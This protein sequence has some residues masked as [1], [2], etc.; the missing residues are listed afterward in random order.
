M[1]QLVIIGAR[2]YGR[3]I[4]DFATDCR[5]YNSDYTI[6]GFL[7]D[8]K[9]ALDDHPGYPPI[10]DSVENY[11]PREDDVF[12]CA[13]GEVKYKKK[14]CEMILAKGGIFTTLISNRAYVSDRNTK[15]GVGC[16]IC[17]DSRI[18]CDVTIGDFVTLQPFAVLGHDVKVGNWCHINDYS[19][20]GGGSQIGNEVTINTQS[21]ILP[22][23][24]VGDRATIG[25]GSIVLRNVKEGVVVF[26]NPA[27]PLPLPKVE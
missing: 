22:K 4:C 5:G 24:K 25:A 8:K 1:K 12:I 21:F 17:P 11:L 9:I 15:I 13:L 19:D 3:E 27:K 20:C 6:K 23:L 26:G 2:G 16:I 7:D 10:L 18:H 14:Y